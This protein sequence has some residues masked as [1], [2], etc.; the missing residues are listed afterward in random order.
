MNGATDWRGAFLAAVNALATA[1][2]VSRMDEGSAGGPGLCALATVAQADMRLVHA[3]PLSRFIEVEADFGIVPLDESREVLLHLLELNANFIQG[4][5][6]GFGIDPETNRVIYRAL[7]DLEAVPGRPLL[8]EL[9]DIAEQADAW[10]AL[11]RPEAALEQAIDL[12][13]PDR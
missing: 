6:R 9:L 4:E 10:W 5:R 12:S 7:F 1:E 11:Q 13:T 3:N 8:A 2:D